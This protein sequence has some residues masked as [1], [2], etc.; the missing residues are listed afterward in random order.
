[1]QTLLTSILDLLGWVQEAPIRAVWVSL[2]VVYATWYLYA[3]VMGFYRAYLNK[4]L[5]GLPLIMAYPAVLA[6]LVFDVFIQLT[7]FSVVFTRPAK[8]V[9]RWHSTKHLDLPYLDIEWLLTTRL[10]RYLVELDP[11]NYRYRL[12][13]WM[14]DHW[15]DPLDPTGSHCTSNPTQRKE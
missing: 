9:V 15:L 1:M 12:T 7:I 3:L 11:S 13:K 4:R 14:C 5:K 6:G 2:L 10:Q 8:V